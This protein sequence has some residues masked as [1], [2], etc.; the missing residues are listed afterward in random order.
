[1]LKAKYY[2]EPSEIDKVV[3]EKLVP[4]THYLRQVKAV[5]DFEPLR[6]LIKDCYSSN[7]GRS[8]E[9]PIMMLKLEFLQFHYN[10]SDREVIAQAGV[11]VAFR[12]FLDLSL[13]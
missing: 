4:A 7:M 6:E 3:F 11:N 10:L 1:M 5:I 8:A 9:D 13:E 12:Y 2:T